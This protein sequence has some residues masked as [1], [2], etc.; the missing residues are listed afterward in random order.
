MYLFIAYN[1]SSHTKEKL[2]WEAPFKHCVCIYVCGCLC[3]CQCQELCVYM[4]EGVC[5]SRSPIV[6]SLY[7]MELS[8]H[9]GQNFMNE[10]IPF[11]I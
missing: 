6:F 2:G 8:P 5:V 9:C 1:G 3:V 7:K 11:R 10:Y 4:C